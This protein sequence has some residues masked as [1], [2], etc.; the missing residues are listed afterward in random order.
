[1][2]ELLEAGLIITLVG[3]TVV[4]VMLTVLIFVIGTMSRLSRIIDVVV[5]AA[6]PASTARP[7][8]ALRRADD[9]ELAGVIGAAIA[10]HRRKR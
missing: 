1:M 7:A 5:A 4:F 8:T 3:M 10:A 2:A 9:D 6:P